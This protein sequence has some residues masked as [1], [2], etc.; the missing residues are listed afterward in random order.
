[1][2]ECIEGSTC[3]LELTQLE[4]DSC[5]R[6][7]FVC[8]FLSVYPFLYNSPTTFYEKKKIRIIF[9]PLSLFTLNPS[10]REKAQKSDDFLQN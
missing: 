2:N 3:E 5:S 9:F 4:H 8:L 10:L 7:G 6:H 1:M